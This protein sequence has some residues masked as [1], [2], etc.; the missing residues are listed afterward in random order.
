MNKSATDK[1]GVYTYNLY[2]KDVCIADL[3]VNTNTSEIISIKT[4]SGKNIYILMDM[5]KDVDSI[6]TGLGGRHELATPYRVYMDSFE[7]CGK[8]LSLLLLKLGELETAYNKANTV[9]GFYTYVVQKGGITKETYNDGVI[10]FSGK[11]TIHTNYAKANKEMCDFIENTRKLGNTVSG[12]CILIG[13]FDFNLTIED[14]LS[15]YEI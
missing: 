13:K 11:S 14:Y 1:Q 7:Q 5:L 15:L 6:V 10:S 8:F 4:I 2:A 3:T 9:D 12:A